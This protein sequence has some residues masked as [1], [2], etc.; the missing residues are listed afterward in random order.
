MSEMP[1]PPP[2]PEFGHAAPVPAGPPP[3][4]ASAIAGFISSLFGCLGITALLG[5]IL[6][7]VGVMKT[8]DGQRRGMGLAV[9]AIVLSCIT[10]LFAVV[11]IPLTVAGVVIGQKMAPLVEAMESALSDENISAEEFPAIVRTIASDDFNEEVSDEALLAWA[12]EMREKHGKVTNF[13]S[14]GPGSTSQTPEGLLLISFN[15][16][17]VNGAQTVQIWLDPISMFEVRLSD[18]AVGGVSV[19]EFAESYSGP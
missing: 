11:L 8:K 7:I 1:P 5:F 6:G 10:G 16:K 19:R 17:F 13:Q 4:S 9:A 14:S 2:S 3:Y 12:L 18:I 15:G